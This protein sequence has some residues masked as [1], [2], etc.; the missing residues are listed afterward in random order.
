MNNVVRVIVAIYG[1]NGKIEG[2]I[3]LESSQQHSNTVFIRQT[4]GAGYYCKMED[5]LAAVRAIQAG[6][7]YDTGPVLFRDQE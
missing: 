5:I 1:G 6:E 4:G 2:K 3:E 7:S